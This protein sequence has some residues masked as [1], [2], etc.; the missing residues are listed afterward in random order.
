MTDSPGGIYGGENAVRKSCGWFDFAHLRRLHEILFSLSIAFLGVS[1]LFLAPTS[2][3]IH[4]MHLEVEINMF[5]HIRQTDLIRGYFEYSIPSALVAFFIWLLLR[6]SSD[7]RFTKEVLRSVAGAVLLLAP[8][9]FW[10]CNYQ[11]VGWPFGW[12]YRWAPFE[13]ALMIMCLSLCLFKKSLIPGWVGV[14]LLLAHFGFWYWVPS[15]NPALANYAGP[16]AP[17]L[18][19]CSAL[20]WGF[21]VRADSITVSAP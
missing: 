1:L 3:R 7:T 10:F 8:P 2:L 14:L 5:L 16:I 13:L 4:F 18:G 6:L 17:I 20:V 19:F 9:I 15:T 12:P 11:V 21:Y